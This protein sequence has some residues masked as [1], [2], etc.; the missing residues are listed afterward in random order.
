M[1]ATFVAIISA[2]TAIAVAALTYIFAK[3]RER[4]SD[5]RR[6]KLDHYKEFV[7]ALSGVVGERSTPANQGR[8]AD[9]V[10]AMTLVAPPSA[11]R[12]LY[13]FQDE[14]RFSNPTKSAQGH[15]EKLSA[16]LREIRRDIHPT[17]PDDGAD[18]PAV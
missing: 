7:A 14:V 9:A 10:N 3:R 11:L 6:L 8:Y 12:A 5:W 1:D 18:V 2:A 13:A 17:Q 16:L 15:D 4:E